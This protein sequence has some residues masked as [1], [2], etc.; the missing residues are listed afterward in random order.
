MISFLGVTGGEA[1]KTTIG[2]D[3]NMACVAGTWLS[4]SLSNRLIGARGV[5]S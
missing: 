2:V 4:S 5:G 3:C 1:G